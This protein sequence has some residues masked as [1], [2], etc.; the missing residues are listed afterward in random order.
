MFFF[1]RGHET[2]IVAANLV[3]SRLTLVYGSS[4]VG[5]SSLL[6]AG[7][8]HELRE[9]AQ[10]NIRMTGSPGAVVVV[11]PA[12]EEGDARRNSWR[13]DPIAELA[14]GI[15]SA[16]AELGLNEERPDPLLRFTEQLEAWAARLDSDILLIL[17]QFEEY[18][19][20]HAAERG[21]GTFFDELSRTLT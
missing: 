15:A 13:D 1:A 17:D 6:R 12:D 20:Y 14:A 10:E 2:S 16:A 21:P 8:V 5:K 18:F 7:V 11:F 9:R 3:A 4:G 19:L